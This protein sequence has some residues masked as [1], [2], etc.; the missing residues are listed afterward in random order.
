[1]PAR[2]CVLV[3]EG[4]EPRSRIL[5]TARTAF[6]FGYVAADPPPYSSPPPPSTF[7]YHGMDG[8][9]HY[10]LDHLT[11]A[12]RNSSLAAALPMGCGRI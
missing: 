9:V 7:A 6:T 3:E 12:Q 1:M 8:S 5:E 11:T 2:A 10:L 4:V